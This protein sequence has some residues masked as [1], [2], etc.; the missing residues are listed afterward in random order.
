MQPPL[1]IERARTILLAEDDPLVRPFASAVLQQQGYVVLSA[2]DATEAL[3][4]YAQYRE[5]IDLLVTDVN[6][7]PGPNGVDLANELRKQ[8]QDLRVLVISGTPESET[9]TTREGLPFLAKPF[10]LPAFLGRVRELLAI[11]R[12]SDNSRTAGG[13]S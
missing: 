6:L 12:P 2:C 11:A 7:G 4:I 1:A 3:T 10:S 5:R 8:R 9:L 13:G